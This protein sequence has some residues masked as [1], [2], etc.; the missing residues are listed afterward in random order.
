MPSRAE[1]YLVEL[2]IDLSSRLSLT[3]SSYDRL[4]VISLSRRITYGGDVCS[5]DVIDSSIFSHRPHGR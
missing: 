1:A 2:G 3:R 5:S 4:T